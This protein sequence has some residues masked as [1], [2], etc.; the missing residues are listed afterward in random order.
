MLAEQGQDTEALR[1]L[2]DALQMHT[3]SNFTY[4]IAE[5]H[6]KLGMLYLHKNEIEQAYYHVKRS[7]ELGSIVS[8]TDGLTN[9]LILHGKILRLSGRLEESAAELNKGLQLAKENGLKKYELLAYEEL[10]ELKKQQGNPEEVYEFYEQYIVLRDT[11][12]NL[13]KSKQIAYMEFENELEKR[14]KALESLKAQEKK[15]RLIQYLLLMGTLILAIGGSFIFVIY[16]QRAQKSKQLV[17]KN[18]ELLESAFELSQK[19]LENAELKQQELKQQLDFKNKELSSYTLNFI[20]KNEIVQQIQKTIQ[21]I[22]KTSSVEKNKLIAD[23]NKIVRKNMS[24]D[25]D[26][27]DFSRFFEDAHQGFYTQL[28]STHPDLSTNDLKICSLIR[29]NLNVKE[30]AS[31]LGISPDS[32]RTARYRLRKKMKLTPEQEILSYLIQ[33]ENEKAV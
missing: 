4:G 25:R 7:M 27:E 19:K 29:L 1:Y 15:D 6:S 31:I 17:A 5:A 20:K 2:T 9:N 22:Q 14:D 10:K 28:K 16:K 21:Q 11:L 12:F 33:L 8:D 32:A 13:E 23:L 26:W 3:D 24:I 30:M 18:Q